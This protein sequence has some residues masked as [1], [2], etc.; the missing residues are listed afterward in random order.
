MQLELSEQEQ[1]LLSEVLTHALSDLREEIFKTDSV[2]YKTGLREREQTL[3]AL[4]GR[5]EAKPAAR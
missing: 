1:A 2:D 3:K 4:V 5:L